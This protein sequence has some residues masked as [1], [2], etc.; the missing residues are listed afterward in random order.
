MTLEVFLIGGA[1]VLI[2]LAFTAA[3]FPLFLGLLP[4]W[5]F[6]TGFLAGASAVVNLDPGTSLISSAVGIGVGIF[7]GALVAVVSLA[8]WWAGIIVLGITLGYSLGA[9]VM[10]ALG[11]GPGLITLVVSMTTAAI[12]GVAFFVLRMPRVFVIV[13][14]AIGGAA[15][16]VAGAMLLLDQVELARFAAGPIGVLRTAGP[17]A[18]IAAIA[19]AVVGIV[20]QMRLAVNTEVRLWRDA[21]GESV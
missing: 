6:L 14:T 5:A 16:T 7:V 1:A 12:V 13:L 18:I 9:G 11:F 17:V 2:G 3:G 15:L 21:T 8:F 10:D 19:L 20:I 4:I